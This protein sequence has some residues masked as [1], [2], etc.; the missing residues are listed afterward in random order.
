MYQWPNAV[1]FTSCEPIPPT[2]MSWHDPMVLL[3]ASLSAVCICYCCTVCLIYIRHNSDRLIKATSRELSYFM[4]IGVLMQYLLL[5]SIVC[6]PDVFVCYISYT[7]FNVSF[8]VVY[9]PLLTR[10]NR[11]Y[12]LFNGG[13][14]GKGLPSLT[15]PLSQ[16]IIAS[17]LVAVQVSTFITFKN[18]F[19]YF[20]VFLDTVCTFWYFFHLCII[21]FYTFVYTL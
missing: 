10:T 14:K 8:A 13:K 12:R 16:V 17:I 15:S 2:S 9:A 5:F 21:S 3:L 1:N 4:W 18:T 6:K 20:S 19:W 7:G 11:I